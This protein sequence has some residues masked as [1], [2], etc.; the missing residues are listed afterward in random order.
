L[1]LA[2][3]KAGANTKN[4]CKREGKIKDA[5]VHGPHS[6]RGSRRKYAKYM[7][8]IGYSSPKNKIS[9]ESRET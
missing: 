7:G 9:K 3:S 6:A 8:K 1:L 5:T 2:Y 4:Y